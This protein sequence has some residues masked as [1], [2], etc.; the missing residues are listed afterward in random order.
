MLG[1]TSRRGRRKFKGMARDVVINRGSIMIETLCWEIQVSHSLNPQ[2]FCRWVVLAT[3]YGLSLNNMS[4]VSHS[5]RVADLHFVQ[6]PM[7]F[8]SH[9]TGGCNREGGTRIQKSLLHQVTSATWADTEFMEFDHCRCKSGRWV[10]G[11]LTSSLGWPH[12]AGH[13]M[14]TWKRRLFKVEQGKKKCQW[15]NCT[16]NCGQ[17]RS[18]ATNS[19]SCWAQDTEDLL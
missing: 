1:R 13:T 10:A 6:S 9:D 14:K 2:Q 7:F 11:L 3:I 4:K 15:F 12:W 8:L 19:F 5:A 18:L 16:M 17:K